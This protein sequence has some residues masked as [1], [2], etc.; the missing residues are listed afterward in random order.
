M[1][2]N[3]SSLSLGELPESPQLPKPVGKPRRET[4][5]KP[6][7]PKIVYY[8][9]SVDDPDAV[10]ESALSTLGWVFNRANRTMVRPDR[11]VYKV[12]S[13]FHVT[14][15]FPRGPDGQA[16]ATTLTNHLGAKVSIHV[17]EI[18]VNDQ[19]ICFGVE[20]I[21][22][23]G[24]EIPYYGNP[25]MHITFAMA[26]PIDGGEKPQAKDSYMALN[27][28]PE[29]GRVIRL[30]DPVTFQATFCAHMSS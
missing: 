16:Q 29:T 6:K 10:I 15:L 5:T 7:E 14:V 4:P 18:G 12:N 24:G 8:K 26:D 20:E 23:D 9:H 11:A 27:P 19:F 13:E 22:C 3:M 21:E 25:V 2:L 28:E 17:T 30:A 1:E